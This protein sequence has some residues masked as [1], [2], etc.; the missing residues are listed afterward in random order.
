M[1]GGRRGPAAARVLPLTAASLA[2]ALDAVGPSRFQLGDLPSVHLPNRFPLSL[3]LL[4]LAG[5]LFAACIW[6]RCLILLRMLHFGD[7]EIDFLP[8]IEDIQRLIGY[9]NAE[10]DV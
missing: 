10:L 9:Y 6:H 5:R 1:N 4:S 7:G 2:L 3:R 8:S